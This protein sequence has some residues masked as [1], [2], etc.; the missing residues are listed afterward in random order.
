MSVRFIVG[1][2]GSG[3]TTKCLDEIRSVLQKNPSGAPIVM[4]VPDQMT[5]QMEYELVKTPGL[6]GMIRAQVFSFSRLALKVL[7][8]VGGLTRYHISSTG[9]N[10][11]LRKV[12]EKE[13]DQLVL[14]NK[15]SEQNG[16]YELLEEMVKEFKRYCL[17]ATDLEQLEKTLLEESDDRNLLR[18]KLHDLHI[19]YHQL[20]AMLEG[21]YVDSEDYLRMLEERMPDSSYFKGCEVWIDGFH[22]YTPQEMGAIRALMKKAKRVNITLT[23][24]GPTDHPASDLDLFRMTNTTYQKLSAIAEE[25]GIQVESVERLEEQH[26]FQHSP[27]IRHL[28][29]Y[30]HERPVVPFYGESTVQISSAV[31]RRA[32]VEGIARDIQELVQ[33]K[34]YRYRDIAILVRDASTYSDLLNT[35]LVDYE[36]PFFLDQK[37][38]MLHHPLI[39]CIRSSLDVI[40]Q[41]W[42]YDPV[43]RCVKTDLLFEHDQWTTQQIR[44]QVDLLENYV[45]AHGIHGK[46]RWT[47][48]EDWNYRK[49]R[50][51]DMNFGS[52]TDDERDKQR[53][54]NEARQMIADPLSRL[55]RDLKASNNGKELCEALFL[56]L[57]YLQVPA[58]LEKWRYDAEQAGDLSLAREHDQVWQAV[59]DL[60]EQMVEIVGEEPLSLD[61]FNKMLNTGLESMRFALVPPSID[62]VLIGSLDRSRFYDVKCTFILGVN[63]G[64]LPAKP[65]E[66]GILSEDDRETLQSLGVE[67]A[68][69]ARENLL[70]ENFLIYMALASASDYLFVSYPLADEEGKSLVPS[71]LINQLKELY[72]EQ[73]ERF[74]MQEPNESDEEPFRFIG[75]PG[76]T[77]SFLTSQL[78]QWQKGYPIASEWWNVYNWFVMNEGWNTSAKRTI[79][80]LFYE[81]KADSLK[82]NTSKQLYG[83]HLKASVSRMEKH[84]SCPFSHFASYGLNLQE[85]QLFRLEAP[86]IGQLFH[87]A[88]KEVAD[89]LQ[90]RK[91]DWRELSSKDCYRIATEVVEKLAPRLQS[92]ILLSSNRYQYIKRKLINVVGRA[93][94]ALS[95]QAKASGFSPIG[96]EL[97]FGNK[98]KIPALKYQ[99]KDGTTMEVIGRIDRVDTATNEDG[100]LLRVIDYKSSQKG[101]NLSE[102]YYGIA[103]QMLT[104]LDVVLTHSDEWL[105][106]EADPAGVLYF[107]VHDP[108]HSSKKLLTLDEIE[109]ELFKKFKMKGYVLEDEDV[110]QLMDNTIEGHSEI[111]PVATKKDGSFRKGSSLLNKEQFDEVRSYVRSMIGSIGSDIM[112]GN[113]DISPYEMQKRTPCTYC[114]FRSVCQFDHSLEEN[115]YRP[116]KNIKDEELFKKMRERGGDEA[117]A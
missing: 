63:D 58:K 86:D 31:N 105:G 45:L 23:S 110:V 12:V 87:A 106:K 94:Y 39:E 57:E 77:L 38:S 35:L 115:N 49:F 80:S 60:M 102:V 61:L 28:E 111:I 32:E 79:H 19:I 36:I 13:R 112:D 54:I 96:L 6:G 59:I 67:M 85:R 3:K 109:K 69:T 90:Q 114:S 14:F 26:R 76:R 66:D 7:Q 16:F 24:T 37:R 71:I 40:S 34:G 108:V 72:P 4:L 91:M 15:S 93:S 98:E 43:F 70:D 22:S 68:P 46:K 55:E 75:R 25:E 20:E 104:Y 8:E 53:W 42:R 11:L 33:N 5:F 65:S 21:Q 47:S 78:R 89:S 95:Q 9:M 48:K 18:D 1:R 64:V 97:E 92:Q 83:D 84:Q 62:Q 44:E 117:D 81:N 101:L 51:L 99:L 74:I 2:S 56:Y 27:S 30:L 107:H 73:S 17:E 103:L 52:Q 50:S 10:M 88:L 116:L 82:S 100:L 113:I 29:N 41:N